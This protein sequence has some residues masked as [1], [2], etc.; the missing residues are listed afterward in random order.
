MLHVCLRP[1]L[2]WHD[3]AAVEAALLPDVRSAVALWNATFS[4][5]YAA[6][7]LRLA[8]ITRRSLERVENA[9]I[10]PFDDVPPGALLVPLDDDDWLA[11]ELATRLLAAEE[12]LRRGYHWNRYVL[13]APRRGRRW[14]WSRRR[15]AADTSRWTC[16][17]NNYAV[18]KL[19]ELRPSFGD[20]VSA[21]AWFDAHPDA[22]RHVPASLSVQNRNLSSRTVLLRRRTSLGRDDLVAD[23][24][25][26]KRLYHGLRLP[27]EVAWA[28]PHVAAMAELM[29]AIRLR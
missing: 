7:R 11:P 1:T 14:P 15:R 28:A 23:Y 27:P 9:K 2:A 13:E 3:E 22:T 6:F 24:E 29:H 18:R 26:H 12:P 25:R 10:V 8:A 16:A 4:L 5:S 21:S 20:H 17:S 19:P